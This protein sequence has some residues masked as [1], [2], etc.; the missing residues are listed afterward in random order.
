MDRKKETIMAINDSIKKGD[1][2]K[3]NM[4]ADKRE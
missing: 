3:R 1:Y 2:K 4:G